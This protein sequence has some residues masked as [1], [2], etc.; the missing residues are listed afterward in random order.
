VVPYVSGMLG[1][2]VLVGGRTPVH[3][4]PIKGQGIYAY[5]APAEPKLTCNSLPHPPNHLPACAGAPHQGAGHLRLRHAHGRHGPP[6]RQPGGRAQAAGGAGKRAV[7]SCMVL[8]QQPAWVRTRGTAGPGPGTLVR[9]AS[10]AYWL[11]SQ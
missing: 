1:A 5:S 4:H 3:E 9:A 11:P 10:R 7:P 2:C 8:Q 6:A